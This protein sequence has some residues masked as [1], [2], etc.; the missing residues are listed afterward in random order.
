MQRTRL[1]QAFAGTI[2]GDLVAAGQKALADFG[3]EMTIHGDFAAFGAVD[4]DGALTFP[5]YHNEK[6]TADRGMCIVVH[7]GG[8][9]VATYACAL[10]RP[11]ESFAGYIR[12]VGLFHDGPDSAMTLYG[13]AESWI[14][15][16]EGPCA[17][18]GGIW[19]KKSCR[20]SEFWHFLV[21]FLPIVGRAFAT[22]VWGAS[23]VIF[24]APTAVVEKGIALRYR[25]LF[26]ESGALWMNRGSE[27][28]MVLGYAA[29]LQ[30]RRDANQFIILGRGALAPTPS[31]RPVDRAAEPALS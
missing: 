16:M 25:P 9:P 15:A 20:R 21:P 11:A 12:D 27:V 18:S 3:A 17:Y 13:E 19:V 22:E 6:T 28:H 26:M 23:H 4:R 29:P 2:M 7:Q 14:D 8:Q 5:G 24:L 1:P 31:P 10:Y 30:I